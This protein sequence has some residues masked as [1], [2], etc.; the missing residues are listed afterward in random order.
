MLERHAI[1]RGLQNVMIELRNDLL[2]REDD[3]ARISSLL[4]GMLTASLDLQPE[5]A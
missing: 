4:A 1:A 5:S 3:V 2:T